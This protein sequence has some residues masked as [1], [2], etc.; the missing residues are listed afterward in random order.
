MAILEEAVRIDKMG[1][2]FKKMIVMR[3]LLRNPK[4]YWSYMRKLCLANVL[5]HMIDSIMQ[6]L[7]EAAPYITDASLK[8]RMKNAEKSLDRLVDA[9]YAEIKDKDGGKEDYERTVKA[10]IDMQD[11]FEVI[12][13]DIYLSDDADA[14]AMRK[15]LEKAIGDILPE[16][17]RNNAYMSFAKSLKEEY[18]EAYD[19]Y[20][21]C[22]RVPEKKEFAD[23]CERILM[24]RN[25]NKKK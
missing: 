17:R 6:D 3:H 22:D 25:D 5:C 2:D 1:K 14:D 9:M 19:A 4:E 7:S 13:N 12:A 15:S 21:R 8:Q 16:E 20:D 11:I 10:A 24:N 18:R 23:T